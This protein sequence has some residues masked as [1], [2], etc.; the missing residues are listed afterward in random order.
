MS[1]LNYWKILKQEMVYENPFIRFRVDE[2]V[3]PDGKPR[4]INVTNTGNS[5]IIIPISKEGL[6]YII[7]QWRHPRNYYSWEFPGGRSDGT[8]TPIETGMRELKEESRLVSK[9]W[10][11]LGSLDLLSGLSENTYDILLAEDVS[12]IESTETGHNEDGVEEIRAVTFAELVELIGNG[13]KNAQSIA[14]LM[15]YL[16]QPGVMKKHILD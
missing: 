1:P 8:E 5:N 14:A 3:G 10:K 4:N 16:S 9:S 7:K 13:I 11:L 2:V 15:L 12:K 6:F